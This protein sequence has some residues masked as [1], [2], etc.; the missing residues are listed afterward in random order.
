[1]ISSELLTFLY[2]SVLRLL[3]AFMLL[4]YLRRNEE[5]LI[6]PSTRVQRNFSLALLSSRRVIL[7][8]VV[9]DTGVDIRHACAHSGGDVGRG[10]TRHLRGIRLPLISAAPP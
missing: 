4:E 10:R 7:C 1:M 2:D 9:G 3:V 6:F 5:L 8:C